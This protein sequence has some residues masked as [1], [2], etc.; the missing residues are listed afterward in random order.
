[1]M[2]DQHF[3]YSRAVYFA[4]EDYE[5]QRQNIDTPR[6]VRKD[7][8][9][10]GADIF[11]LPEIYDSLPPSV[12]EHLQDTSVLISSRLNEKPLSV[13][14]KGLAKNN[15]VNTPQ[16]SRMPKVKGNKYKARSQ[17]TPREKTKRSRL[18]ALITQT[19][20]ISALQ[21]KWWMV[22]KI[23]NYLDA[24]FVVTGGGTEVCRYH[25]NDVMMSAI[26]S[27]ITSLT[28]VYSTVYSDADQ[29]KHQS[30][31]SL[32]SVRGI[33]RWPVN[34]PHKLPV[35]RKVFP[36]DDVI[37]TTKMTL[38]PLSIFCQCRWLCFLMFCIC[39]VM[40]FNMCNQNMGFYAI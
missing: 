12:R 19:R 40:L 33:H 7:N 20:S 16:D 15:L 27:Q 28:I 23:E 3:V 34:S 37:M 30:S 17:S 22:F 2:C 24:N 21:A 11:R 25:C 1:M 31:S 18:P 35:S 39:C 38:L 5:A 8:F 10:T 14:K 26:A 32:A 13:P 4:L 6:S 9:I 29:R 36:F